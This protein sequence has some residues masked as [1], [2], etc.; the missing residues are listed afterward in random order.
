[1]V[2]NIS[3]STRCRPDYETLAAALRARSLLVRP[4][5]LA[6]V[7]EGAALAVAASA[8]PSSHRWVDGV[9]TMGLPPT[10]ELGLAM[11]GHHGLGHQDRC[12]EPSFS[13]DEIIAGVSPLP[14]WMIHSTRDELVEEADY[15]R[16]DDVAREPKRLILIDAKNHRFTDRL[17]QLKEQVMDGLAWLSGLSRDPVAKP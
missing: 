8:A 2:L 9:M 14:L 1:M 3:A 16:F 11:E 17:P 13:P 4:V 15:R 5:I 10:A 6:G 7:S 12:D